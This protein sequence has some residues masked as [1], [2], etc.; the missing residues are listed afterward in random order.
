MKLSNFLLPAIFAGDNKAP[1]DVALKDVTK[2]FKK[3]GLD[4][5]FEND[6]GG[7]TVISPLSIMG[8]LF[9]A[10]AGAG[11]NS[12]QEIFESLDLG[13]YFTSSE[14]LDPFMAYHE[15][16]SQLQSNGST[17]SSGDIFE[18]A[19]TNGLFYQEGLLEGI[20]A[21][22]LDPGTFDVLSTDFVKD[23]SNVKALN[24]HQ[25]APDS[26]K[27]IN[28]WASEATK[29]KI[30]N[31]FKEDLSPD[32]KIVMASALYLKASWIPKFKAID[33]EAR[34]KLKLDDNSRMWFS[35]EK[36]EFEVRK[37]IEQIWRD[38]G[39]NYHEYNEDKVF[40][41]VIELPMNINTKEN[42]KQMVTL[43]LWVPDDP[44]TSDEMIQKSIS[45][46]YP[47]VRG[48]FKRRQL[49][50]I[51]PKFSLSFNEDI[52]EGLQQM[53]MNDIFQEGIA[54]FTPILG[55][56]SN[57]FVSKVNHAV[58]FELDEDGIEGAAV[59]A[60]TISSRSMSSRKTI[61]LDRPFYF[62]VTNRCWENNRP[63][64]SHC[65]FENLPIFMGRVVDPVK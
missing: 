14:V 55:E 48:H 60:V 32:T 24:F 42:M 61:N 2:S 25:S 54:D 30:D 52:K 5:F 59:T 39:I 31:L 20:G 16:A 63:K 10:A 3:N 7:N 58:K 15:I 18:L 21:D 8:A 12:R 28:S 26:T 43:Q 50:L 57:A 51:I 29:G 6:K 53:G 22:K 35:R 56:N 38:G 34:K 13:E 27:Y 41:K 65:N 44:L 40:M 46:K 1:V 49:R 19:I 64:Q 4:I 17:S 37:E 45:K 36:G 33:D 9:M 23:I 47:S 11:G 62:I